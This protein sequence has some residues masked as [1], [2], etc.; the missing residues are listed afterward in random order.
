MAKEQSQRIR[1]K[2][3]G[4]GAFF[5]VVIPLPF[6]VFALAW[7][8]LAASVNFLHF[9]AGLPLALLFMVAAVGLVWGV[10]QGQWIEERFGET[11]P[12][13]SFAASVSVS[14]AATL[15]LLTAGAWVSYGLAQHDLSPVTTQSARP[16]FNALVRTYLWHFVDVIPLTNVEKTFGKADPEVTFSG[17]LAGLPILAFRLFVVIVILSV[18]RSAWVLFQKAS[19]DALVTRLRQGEAVASN[20]STQ[21][22][23]RGDVA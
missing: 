9:W 5:W 22:E 16:T 23:S 6:V 17:W 1:P 2:E 8:T 3:T 13:V 10:Y 20:K 11:V 4:H 18:I 21:A 7:L 12:A 14:L 15:I 19:Q